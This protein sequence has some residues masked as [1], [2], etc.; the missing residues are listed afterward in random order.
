MLICRSETSKLTMIIKK[1][2]TGI[3]FAEGMKWLITLV[4]KAIG[5][6]AKGAPVPILIA[7]NSSEL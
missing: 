2:I 5:F 6:D 7:R 1:T 4:C 3:S